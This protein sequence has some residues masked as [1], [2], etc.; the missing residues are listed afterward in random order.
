MPTADHLSPTVVS[1]AEHLRGGGRPSYDEG[2]MSEHPVPRTAA[3]RAVLKIGATLVAGALALALILHAPFARSAVLRYVLTTVQRDHGLTLDVARLDYN[4]ATL[5]VGLAAVRLSTPGF[6]SEP[7][8]EADYLS[9]TLPLGALFG[10]VAVKDITITNARAFVHRRTDGTTNLPRTEDGAGVEPPALHIDRLNVPRLAIDLRDEQASSSLQVPALA[11]VLTPD[12]GSV[13]LEMPAELRVGTHTTQIS[14]LRGEAMF[15][16]RTLGLVGVELR[17]DEASLTLDGAFLLFTSDPRIDLRLVGTGEMAR[18]AR[19]VLTD[20]ELPQGAIAFEGT[21]TGPMDDPQAQVE[22]RTARASWHGVTASDLAVRLRVGATAADVQELRAVFADGTVTAAGSLPLGADATGRATVSWTGVNAALATAAILPE[23]DL[24]PS[25]LA[26]GEIGVEGILADASTWSGSLRLQMAP[27]RNARGR[28]AVGGDLTLDWRDGIWRMD[29]QPTL[30]GVVPIQIGVRGRLVGGPQGQPAPQEAAAEDPPRQA[31]IASSTLEGAVR[32]AETD[33]P[34]LLTVLRTIGIT[35][36]TEAVAAGTLDADIDLGG[37]LGDPSVSVRASVSGIAG[38]QFAGESVS[39]RISG[40]PF[41]PRLEFSIETA[42]GVVAG[43]RLNGVR[44]AGLMTGTSIVLDELSARQPA[45]PGVV[46]GRGAYDLSA[47][48]YTVSIEGAEWLLEATATQ[49]LGG[50]MHIRFTGAGNAKDPRGTGHVTLADAR[51]QDMVLGDLDAAVRLDGRVA[52]IDAKAPDFDAAATARVQLDAPYAA[53]VDAQ[54]GSLDL[55]RVLQDVETPAPIT[56]SASLALRFEGPLDGW[57][58]GSAALDVASLDASAGDLP[59]HL[60]QPAR[61]RYEAERVFVDSLE[62]DAGGTRLSAS[63]ALPAFEPAQETAGLLVTLTGG[64]GEVVRAAAATGL[65]DVAVT[66]GSGPVALL[67]R[68]SGSLQTPTVAADLEMGPGSV[69]LQDVRQISGVRLRA[70]AEDGW[71]ELRE[72]AASYQDANIAVTARAP[73]SWIVPGAGGAAGDGTLHA[74]ATNLTPAIL[75]PFLDATTIAQLTGSID[76]TLDAASAT[77]DLSALTGELRVDRLDVRVTDLPVTQRVPTRIV[78]RDGFARVEAWDWVGQGAT[79]AVRGQVRLEDRQAAILA[80]GVVDL[81]MVTPFVRDAGMTVA[82]RLE[83]RL[84]ITGALDNPRVDGD[85]TVTGGEIRFADPRI[86]VSDLDVRTVLTRTS[87]RITSLT[88]SV[89]GGTLTGSGT[90][91]DSAEGGLSAQLST[92]IRGMAMEFPE[93][94]RSEVDADLDLGVDVLGPSGRLSGTVTVARGTYREPLAVVTGLLAGMRDARLSPG[95][96][97]PTASSQLLESFALDVRLLTDEDVVV[98]NNYGRFQLGADLRVIGTAAA[99]AL[100]GRAELGEGGQLF[101]GRNIYTIDSGSFDFAN[102]VTIEPDLN[103]DLRTRAAGHDIQVTIAGTTASPS[104]DQRSLTEPELG[105]AE[106]ASLLL[107]GRRLE[108][109]APGDA[110]FVGTQ[111]LGNFSAEVLGFAS[112]AVGLDT[113]RLGD[114]DNAAVRRDPTAVATEIDP[115]TR[116]T[117]GKTLRPDLDVTFSQSLRDSEAQTWI[118]EYLPARAVELRLVSDDSDLRS[119]EFRHDVMFGGPSR[120]IRPAAALA[121]T[122]GARVATVRFSGEP[123][124][125]ESRLRGV[126]R[127]GPG[128]RFDFADWQ[129]DGD[130]LEEMYHRERYLTARVTLTRADGP[131]GIDL[132]YQVVAGPE[133]RLLV[134]GIDVSPALRS[135]LEAAWAQSVFDDF[136]VDEAAQIVRDELARAR[137]LRPAVTVRMVDEG[138]ARILS[139]EVDR[140]GITVRS[141]V[142]VEGADEPLARGITA[143]LA[144]RG[145]VDE[146]ALDPAAVEREV[147]EYLR[148][149]GHLRARVTAGAP[150]FEG[151]VAVVPVNVDAGSAFSIARVAFEGAEA[152]ADDALRETAALTE[153]TPYAPVGADAARERLAAMYRREGFL[154][155]TVTARPD[156]LTDASAVD[157]TFVVVEGARQLL[158]EVV[159]IGNRAIA[160]DVIVRALGLPIGTPLRTEDLLRARVRV[161]DTG[162]FRRVDVE[163]EPGDPSAGDGRIVPVRLRV[164]VEE[165]P[166]LRLRYGFQVKEE[167]PESEIERRDLVPGLSADLTRRT[168]FGRAIA[169]G[170]AVEWQRRE[171]LGRAFLDTGTFL[172]LPIGSSLVAERSREEFAAVT[173]VTDRSS[174]TWG[175]RARVASNLSLSYAY[176]FERNHTF[177]TK[178]FDP[179]SL[180]FDI[181]I[182]IA[183]LNAAT[184]WDTRDDPV[185]TSRGSLASFSLEYAPEALGSD[186]R[187][188]RSVAQA[189]HFRPWRGLVFASA[190]RAGTVVP[191]GGQDLIPSERFF[192]GGARTVRGV[193]EGS[194]GARDFFGDPAGGE[195]LIVLNQEVR[196]PVYRWLRGVGFLD[197]GNVFARPRDASLRGLVGS[198]G[199]GLRLA[200]PF[201]L[202]RADYGRLIWGDPAGTSGRWSF[203][204][205]HA[206]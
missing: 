31:G 149:A 43:Q 147:A 177:D 91:D 165:W 56:G 72:G 175:Q 96:G 121:E 94:L 186:I 38:P 35:A 197:T 161:F 19:W 107:T 70:H 114:V 87:A 77:P 133:T 69:T 25:A 45:G 146:A 57:R 204:I 137:Y 33:L 42:E 102:P 5:R 168:L 124:I 190:A 118:V 88:G 171:R 52:D 185:D 166:A 36:I 14:Q 111:V 66:G 29:G 135:R 73:L 90:L 117:F 113:L 188:V 4:L 41:Q 151:D 97:D 65:T 12:G 82:G 1:V 67:A 140:G 55:A 156:I 172:G 81:R 39:A 179:G 148:S 169:I 145:L 2:W 198:I 162:L 144:E 183:R 189:Y 123:V 160:T 53:L 206:F 130:R 105:R 112:R 200:S 131:D 7:F 205:G 139:V 128:D 170:G 196:V 37:S 203:G 78:A 193:A 178:P 180:A 136:L 122:N 181:T 9:V 101:V 120:A 116:L 126:L 20:E 194:L 143:R 64:V 74:R 30:A 16:G 26:S 23:A 61:L 108:D 79:L 115:T 6:A 32:L 21:V 54:T 195:M 155:A 173:L 58:T 191:L 59:I 153:G 89:N 28:I 109:L 46:A 44:A 100:A 63:G 27:G 84:S 119:Y 76:A 47:G 129:A 51:W 138:G 75:A 93:G 15:D 152:V 201:A 34:T 49:P 104:V 83:P 103:I 167:R 80:N 187:F 86:L 18:L 142:R 132:D 184:A 99:P 158:G 13:S 202:L 157:L 85:L 150:L 10:D 159:V 163:S 182:N 11:L 24:V 60:A 164:T 3:V 134:T 199:F 192:A 8:F 68:I 98:D 127:L 17:T 95:A 141:V 110:A 106:V 154:S 40:R 71:L 174:V 92:S 48:E 50:R 125:P 22:L 62:A 176:T